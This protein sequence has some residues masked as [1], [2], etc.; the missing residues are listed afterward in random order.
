MCLLQFPHQVLLLDGQ[1]ICCFA[2]TVHLDVPVLPMADRVL[3]LFPQLE[4]LLLEAGLLADVLFE[5]GVGR[6]EAAVEAL[7]VAFG[8]GGEVAE[9]V[10]AFIS[11]VVPE[12]AQLVVDLLAEVGVGLV[13]HAVSQFK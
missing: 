8:V 10:L 12:L 9:K 1:L 3:Q 5:G 11:G 13:L 4:D 7:L 2:E 6:G